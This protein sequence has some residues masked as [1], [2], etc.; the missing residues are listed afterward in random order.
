MNQVFNMNRLINYAYLKFNMNK[1]ML[2]LSIA[3]FFGVLFVISFFIAANSK[4]EAEAPF[5]HFHKF[6]FLLMLFGGEI[7]IAGR[8]FQ[9]MNTSEKALTQIMIPAS[10][11]EKFTINALFSSVGWAL[12]TFALYQTFGLLINALWASIYDLNFNYFITIDVFNISEEMLVNAPDFY[13]RIH[14]YNYILLH[15]FFF[16]GAT[17]FKKHPIVK[18]ALTF[19]LVS[20]FYLLIGFV[21]MLLFFGSFNEMGHAMQDFGDYLTANNIQKEDLKPLISGFEVFTYYLF[22]L[23]LYVTSYFKMQE[24]EV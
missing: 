4:P 2:F 16:L 19:F 10:K 7:V 24:R 5:E 3:G 21:M 9:D 12:I 14:I 11:L 1:K 23:I 17:A 8:S 13:S 6:A 15:A 20:L 22:P 18:T